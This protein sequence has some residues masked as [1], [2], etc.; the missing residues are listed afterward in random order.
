[1]S[2]NEL[3]TIVAMVRRGLLCSFY[4]SLMPLALFRPSQPRRSYGSGGS[5]T[6]RHMAKTAA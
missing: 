1:M 6:I 3:Q 2:Y 5:G 4:L